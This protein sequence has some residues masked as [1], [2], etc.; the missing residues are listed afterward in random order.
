MRT[1]IIGF[2]LTL[3]FGQVG[4]AQTDSLKVERF[5]KTNAN[6]KSFATADSKL[7]AINDSGK[8]VIWDL[9]KLDTIHF[10]HNDKSF[11]YTAI[12]K[13]RN[14]QIF[15]GTNKGDI[16]KINPIDLSYSLFLDDKYAVH[17]ICFNTDNKMFLIVRSAVYEPASKKI[18]SNFKHKKSRNMIVKRK[19]FGL[20]WKRIYNYLEM[21][22]RI[23]MD[24]QDRIWMTSCY[25]EFGGSIQ[26]FDAKKRKELNDEFE[27]LNMGL[28]FP[29]SVFG[30][31]K[32]NTYITSGLQH[33]T[34]SGEIYK[35]DEHNT[36]TKIYNS[37]DYQDTTKKTGLKRFEEEGVFVGPG[38]YNKTDHSIYFATTRGF[39]KA[40]LPM[41]GKLQ[42]PQ[43]LFNPTLTWESEPLANGV[44]M[45][46]QHIEFT[47]DN[48]LLFLTSND[49]FGIFHNN[50]LIFLK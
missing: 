23:A 33:F 31:D 6:Y 15:I 7:F 21:P 1:L 11:R 38:A 48:K 49:G 41:T 34:N 45:A 29:K 9:N 10:A 24:N 13:D 18:W 16:Y 37:H 17:A 40:A 2:I 43:L 19:V 3:F 42:N 14:N 39:Y 28:L 44:A 47:T 22:Q 5:V 8:V 26:L 25:G 46:I 32:G 35:I 12:S 4:L 20:F 27:G 36:V 50:K 30:D